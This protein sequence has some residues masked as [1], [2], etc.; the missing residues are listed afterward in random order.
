MLTL[1]PYYFK[2]LTFIDHVSLITCNPVDHA[3]QQYIVKS[4]KTHSKKLNNIYLFQWF[5]DLHLCDNG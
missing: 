5:K 4:I 3:S 2:S 1:I